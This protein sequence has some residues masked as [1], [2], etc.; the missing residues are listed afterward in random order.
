MTR[1]SDDPSTDEVEIEEITL[2]EPVALEPDVEERSVKGPISFIVALVLIAWLV[3]GLNELDRRAPKPLFPDRTGQILVFQ[4]NRVGSADRRGALYGAVSIIDV[5]RRV[6]VRRYLRGNRPGDQPYFLLHLG[7]SFV[8]GWG[9][10]YAA[11]LDG[12][13]PKRIASHHSLVYPAAEPGSVLVLQYEST[14]YAGRAS[15]REFRTPTRVVRRTKTK[16][17]GYGYTFASRGVTGGMA[18]T[19]RRGVELWNW[20]RQS[21]TR[22]YGHGM[23]TY[24]VGGR[25]RLLVWCEGR[26]E[27]LHLTTIGGRDRVIRPPHGTTFGGIARVSP[28]GKWVGAVAG[29]SSPTEPASWR[30]SIVVLI[31]AKTGRSRVVYRDRTKVPAVCEGAEAGCNPPYVASPSWS[32][33]SRRLF[34]VSFSQE[35][36]DVRLGEYVVDSHETH[37]ALV[38][39]PGAIAPTAFDA[40]DA[41]GLLR[42]P[43][44]DRCVVTDISF[45]TPTCAARF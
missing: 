27:V 39:V 35:N 11:P 28:D 38:P 43:I 1:G 2:E 13:A 40:D 4:D 29:R 12:R 23:Q 34:F 37:T 21:F 24:A 9:D 42:V 31:D 41:K 44:S 16:P 3:F 5:D 14:S 7:K 25:R 36:D 20:R 6:V 15:V 45:A 30:G 19:T 33:D 18:Y 10:I 17:L 22:R 32:E 8:Y 26:C